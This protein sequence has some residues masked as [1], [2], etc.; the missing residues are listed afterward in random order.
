MVR[1]RYQND[2]WQLPVSAWH[3]AI[4]LVA[5]KTDTQSQLEPLPLLYTLFVFQDRLN[6][7]VGEIGRKGRYNI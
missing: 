7:G 3:F 1:V 4:N 6:H 5:C 2:A